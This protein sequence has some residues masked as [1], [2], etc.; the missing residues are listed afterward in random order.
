ME[1][2]RRKLILT[3]VGVGAVLLAL[4]VLRDSLF[5][6]GNESIKESIAAL[7]REVREYPFAPL[8][9]VLGFVVGGLLLVPVTVIIGAT[10]LVFEPRFGILTA[11]AGVLASASTGYRLGRA[12]GED[13]LKRHLKRSFEK[14]QS[15]TGRHGILAVFLIRHMPVAPFTVVNMLMGA[16]KVSFAAMVIGTALGI[17]PGILILYYVKSIL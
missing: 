16:A 11:L 15:I 1:T 6:T 3:L 12:L 7:L 4:Y 13:F 17:G 10:V 8:I 2:G 9:V 5:G 14:F